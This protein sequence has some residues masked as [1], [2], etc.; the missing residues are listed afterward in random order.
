M[1]SVR[2]SRALLAAIASL[3]MAFYAKLS[4]RLVQ[5]GRDKHHPPTL[6]K[7]A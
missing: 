2:I 5:C 6:T 4:C 1:M 7:A 3:V